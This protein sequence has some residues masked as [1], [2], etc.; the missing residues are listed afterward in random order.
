MSGARKKVIVRLTTPGVLRGYLAPTG[1]VRQEADGPF[2]DLLDLAGRVQVVALE[3]V[4]AISFVREFNVND[5]ANPERLPRKTFLARP[6]S[7]GLW[8]RLTLRNQ[9]QIEGLAPLDLSLTDGI[10]EDLGVQFTP[11][12]V[13]GNTQRMY[14]PRSALAALQIVAVVTTPTRRKLL[15]KLIAVEEAQLALALPHLPSPQ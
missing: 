3:Q 10:A 2:L 5:E 7:E 11:P 4:R 6:R 14:V 1:F 15:E 9:D 12:D 8:I 13:R